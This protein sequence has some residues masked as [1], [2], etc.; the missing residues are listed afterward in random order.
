[1]WLERYHNH[2]LLDLLKGYGSEFSENA[3]ELYGT[4]WENMSNYMQIHAPEQ[5]YMILENTSI[6]E[7][8]FPGWNSPYLQY[9]MITYDSLGG[10]K[11]VVPSLMHGVGIGDSCTYTGVND[12][13]GD[14]F[15]ASSV[16]LFQNYPN[17]FSDYTTIE[18]ELKQ[19]SYVS[20]KVYDLYG[21]EIATLVSSENLRGKNSVNFYSEQLQ[22][23]I[24]YVTLIT[25]NFSVTRKMVI[26]R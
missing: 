20:L 1:M 8:T 14:G 17:P 16:G 19:N 10:I 7:G 12:D 2:I 3:R 21:H 9:W 15:Y 5:Y 22:N 23:G 6:L 26:I 24:Y 4:G 11:F 25:G 18:Y 13:K